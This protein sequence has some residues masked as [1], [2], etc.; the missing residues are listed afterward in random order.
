[1]DMPAGALI[2]PGAE[3]APDKK[4]PCQVFA[5]EDAQGINASTHD[6]RQF[7]CA[8]KQWM[9]KAGAAI[10]GEHPKGGLSRKSHISFLKGAY[11]GKNDFQAPAGQTAFEKVFYQIF[12]H[13]NSMAE[14][15]YNY[16]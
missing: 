1:M 10:N 3:F 4:A 13:K 12:Y 7:F 2:I 6:K 15:F 9:K 14:K 8:C 11:S 16:A 5:C